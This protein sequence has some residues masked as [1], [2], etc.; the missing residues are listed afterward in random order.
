MYVWLVWSRVWV[1]GNPGAGLEGW[2]RVLK[3]WPFQLAYGPSLV[4]GTVL[5]EY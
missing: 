4:S 1:T 3:P 2:S 5:V